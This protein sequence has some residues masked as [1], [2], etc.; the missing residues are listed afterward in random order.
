MH[1]YVDEA[2]VPSLKYGTSRYFAVGCILTPGP[3]TLENVVQN[4][5]KQQGWSSHEELKFSNSSPQIRC[6]FLNELKDQ[7]I[8]ACCLIIKKAAIAVREKDITPGFY[9]HGI[10][11]ALD[12]ALVDLECERVVIDN[13][14]NTKPK[15]ME[16]I[17]YLRHTINQPVRRVGEFSIGDS[18]RKPGLQAADM[19]VSSVAHEH[20]R[21]EGMYSR[22]IDRLLTKHF[23]P[24][25]SDGPL[26]YLGGPSTG[27]L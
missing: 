27:F 9:Q 14:L 1:A 19:V 11:S 3:G 7:D 13:Y 8:R 23:W 6:D 20:E 10:A 4:F 2:G 25:K 21:G 12:H 22:I 17:S 5:K 26:S 24:Q 16:F 18:S 15:N